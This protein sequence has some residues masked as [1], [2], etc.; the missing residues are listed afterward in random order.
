MM[1]CVQ[2]IGF[3]TQYGN[4]ASM[5]NLTDLEQDQR[6]YR[7]RIAHRVMLKRNYPIGVGYATPS[8][9]SAKPQTEERRSSDL[10][11]LH[12]QHRHEFESS[13]L[14]HWIAQC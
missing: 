13:H 6:S 2:L 11:F 5:L 10:H 8:G 4:E 7:V 1:R 12:P 9:A 14:G 3:S